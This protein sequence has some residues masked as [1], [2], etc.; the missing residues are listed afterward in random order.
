M[1]THEPPREEPGALHEAP[2][3]ARA[4]NALRWVLFAG[5]LALAAVS[6]ATWAISRRGGATAQQAQARYHCP[7]HPSYTS[8]RPGE[9][10]ICGMSLEPIPADYGTGAAADTSDVPGLA[11]VQLSPERIQL[12]GVRTAVAERSAVGGRLELVG[13]VTPDE[14]RF[15]RVQIRLTGWVERI[16][17]E[18]AGAPVRAGEPLV[19]IQSPELF[20]TEQEYVIERGAGGQDPGAGAA[21]HDSGARGAASHDSGAL[22]AVRQRL[23]SLGVPADEIE[24]LERERTASTRLMLRAPI[25]GTV[26]EKNVVDGQYVGPD[27]P[28]FTL[29][30]LS[31]VWVLADVYAIDVARVAVGDR[32]TFITDAVPDRSFAGR[33]DF[34]Y[35]TIS[36]ETRTLKVRVTLDNPGG[37]LRPGSYGRV[38]VAGRAGSALTVPA[39]AVIRTGDQHYVFLARAG[40]RFEPRGVVVGPQQGDRVAVLEGL[41]AGDTVVASASFLIDSESRLKAAIAGRGAPAVEHDHGGAK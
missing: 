18:Q 40:G 13:F 2:R 3:G 37:V 16:H 10:P 27:T 25:S 34:V 26:L 7:M 19:T 11:A 20:Q 23:Q 14:S 8:D 35:P 17:V 12:I 32:A 6:V 38:L 15:H 28:L 22:A 5:L 21:T 31:R 4:M 24:R 30:D 29:A 9:C 41:A 33:V 1:T 39:E 36:P